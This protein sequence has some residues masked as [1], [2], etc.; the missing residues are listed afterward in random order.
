M[1]TREELLATARELKQPSPEVA[2][3]FGAKRERLAAEG[4]R[5]MGARRDLERLVGSG[6]QAMAE[7]NNR[8]FARFME[9][10]FRHYQPEVL[11]ETVLWVF[12]AYRS[13]G[14][15]TT[16]WP[17]NLDTWVELLRG[18]LSGGAFEAVYPFYDWLIVHIPWFVKLTDEQLADQAD[19]AE[20]RHTEG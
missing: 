17:A 10:L 4:N 7:D 19:Q 12:R 20:D 5:R 1:I 2:D 15:Q 14:F 16:Y 9:S 11:V 18:E 13:H 6:N 3:E 8:N